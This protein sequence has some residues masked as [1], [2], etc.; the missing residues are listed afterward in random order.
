M[1]AGPASATVGKA[2][3]FKVISSWVEAQ[4][5]F[6]TVQRS[7]ALVPAGTPVT[8][9]VAEFKLVIVAVPL[10][11]LHTPVPTTGAV[12]DM[13]NVPVLHCVMLAGPATDAL[14]EA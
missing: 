14:G 4:T 7:T 12:A 10:T 1:L 5:P 9:V 11:I 2:S 3:L 6:D 8:V 13:V